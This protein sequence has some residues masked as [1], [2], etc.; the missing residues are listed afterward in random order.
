M[1]VPNAVHQAHP[2][3][4][5][6]IAP[7]FTLLDAW[8]LPVYGSRGDFGSLVDMMAS[9]DPAKSQS[10]ATRALF[11]LRYQL[12]RWFGWDDAK[13]RPIPGCTETTLH[14]RLP[15]ELRDSAPSKGLSGGFTP[16]YRTDD[17][18]AAEIT[19]ATVHGVLQLGWVE[20]DD[21]RYRAQMGVYVKPRGRF[22]E[23]YLRLIEPFRHLIVYPALTRQIGRAWDRAQVASAARRAPG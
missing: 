4:I 9:L 11:A 21:G 10:T 22:G 15:R 8:A 20:Q 2:W 7:D 14:A 17:E 23:A 13:Q 5:S 3:M 12:G 16:L 18:W 6:R 1:R 19:N